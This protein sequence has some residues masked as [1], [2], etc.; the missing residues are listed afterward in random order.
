MFPKLHA[1][2]L[3]IQIL[4]LTSPM[5]SFAS[6][7]LVLYLCEK[8]FDCIKFIVHEQAMDLKTPFGI[9]VDHPY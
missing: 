9:N 3:I 2:S 5:C 6:I 8:V 4:L 7:V 1:L